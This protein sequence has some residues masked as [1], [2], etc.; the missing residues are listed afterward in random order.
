MK[1]PFELL[2][3][4]FGKKEQSWPPA[5]PGGTQ[6]RQWPV[7]DQVE[8]IMRDWLNVQREFAAAYTHWLTDLRDARNPADFM[9]AQQAGF[10]LW[11]QW[12]NSTMRALSTEA[13]EA[14]PVSAAA[15]PPAP[16]PA[17]VPPI[18]EP[19]PASAA[20]PQKGGPRK[21]GGA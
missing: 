15:A 4:P 20:A 9:H 7:P 10:A 8:R 12:L 18:A 17:A 14:A 19:E 16:A 2:P 21:K 11:T 3:F 5:W 6:N 1:N 13:V